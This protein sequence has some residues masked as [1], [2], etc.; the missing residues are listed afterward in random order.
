MRDN[1]H[2]ITC[3]HFSA[4]FPVKCC[5]F[6]T[7]HLRHTSKCNAYLLWTFLFICFIYCYGVNI[8]C[9]MYFCAHVKNSDI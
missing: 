8:Y 6:Q 4:I 9:H 3:A 2:D 7:Y 5:K 1:L